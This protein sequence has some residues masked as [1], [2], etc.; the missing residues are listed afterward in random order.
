MRTQ[1]L[2]VPVTEDRDHEIPQLQHVVSHGQCVWEEVSLKNLSSC[3]G[4]TD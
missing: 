1:E 2:P 3:K 4:K